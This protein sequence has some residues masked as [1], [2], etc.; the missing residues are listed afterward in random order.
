MYTYIHFQRGSG[1]SFPTANTACPPPR[2]PA[3]HRSTT[4][5]NPLTGGTVMTRRVVFEKLNAISPLLSSSFPPSKQ[6]RHASYTT[7]DTL[8]SMPH[9]LLSVCIL[10]L[11]PL[12]VKDPSFRRR[13]RG[14][15]APPP[16][17]ATT[18]PPETAEPRRECKAVTLAGKR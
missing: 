3:S 15:P 11:S 12:C 13:R 14:T 7:P 4:H 17:I 1:H 18:I 10:F 16:H 8:D 6:A 5:Q 9:C 2:A